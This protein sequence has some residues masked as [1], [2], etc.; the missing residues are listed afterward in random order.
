MSGRHTAY[1][2]KKNARQLGED[3][4]MPSSDSSNSSDSSDSPRPKRRK[5]RNV[6]EG[7]ESVHPGYGGCTTMNCQTLQIF[8]SHFI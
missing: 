1:R 7:K 8:T 2:A 3:M 5:Q 4:D 6:D